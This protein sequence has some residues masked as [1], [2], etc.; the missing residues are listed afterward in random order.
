MKLS[1]SNRVTTVTFDNVDEQGWLTSYLT[2]QDKPGFFTK[3]DGTAGHAGSKHRRLFNLKTSTF[4]AG[5]TSTV[6][7]GCLKEGFGVEVNDTRKWPKNPLGREVCDWLYPYQHEA[8]ER[9]LSR[10]RGIVSL[11]TASGKCLA[12]DT[13]VVHYDGRVTR[14]CDVVVG[15]QLMGPD[16]R[17]RN[18]LSTTSGIGPRYRVEP[19]AG[20]AWECNDVHVLTLVNRDSDEIIDIPLNDFIGKSKWFRDTHYSF[21]TGVEWAPAP[22]LPI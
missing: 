15:D 9:I 10:T 7:R 14:A 22:P 13:P 11:P 18:V 21:C 12:P 20:D 2:F 8:V 4:P 16:S 5:L 1:L 19:K 17:P 6:Y 3:A